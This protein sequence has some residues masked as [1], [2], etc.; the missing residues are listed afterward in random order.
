MPVRER[1]YSY[2][3]DVVV[4]A[5]ACQECLCL[6]LTLEALQAGSDIKHRAFRDLATACLLDG[7]ETCTSSSVRALPKTTSS[8]LLTPQLPPSPYVDFQPSSLL[9]INQTVVAEASNN[10]V[11]VAQVAF[12][13]SAC[14]PTASP[15]TLQLRLEHWHHG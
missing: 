11:N 15:E 5:A 1:G 3:A 10:F 4:E 13:Q 7:L 14:C 6:R 8:F 2:L 9:S 12:L